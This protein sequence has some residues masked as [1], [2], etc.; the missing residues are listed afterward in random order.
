MCVSIRYITELVVRT[1]M[2]YTRVYVYTLSY[3]QLV[4]T[5]V[6]THQMQCTVND[7]GQQPL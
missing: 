4:H 6:Y 3:E 2:R 7:A 1:Y 5:A